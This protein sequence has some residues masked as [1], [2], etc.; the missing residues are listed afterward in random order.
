M[1]ETEKIIDDMK[2]FNVVEGNKG[3][4]YQIN[5]QHVYSL[6]RAIEQHVIKVRIGELNKFPSLTHH[7]CELRDKRIA[8]LKKGLTP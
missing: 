7:Q 6:A 4:S 1:K 2:C 3:M 5:K 8:Q